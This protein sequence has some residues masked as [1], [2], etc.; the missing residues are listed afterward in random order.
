MLNFPEN[1]SFFLIS[2]KQNDLFFQIHSLERLTPETSFH[3]INNFLSTCGADSTSCRESAVGSLLYHAPLIFI[4]FLVINVSICD[5]IFIAEFWSL[6]GTVSYSVGACASI[7]EDLS[8][9]ESTRPIKL[10]KE[11]EKS[12]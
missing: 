4:I 3:I 6:E 7:S 10:G 8:S 12:K 11:V 5:K 2:R 1:C 9:G